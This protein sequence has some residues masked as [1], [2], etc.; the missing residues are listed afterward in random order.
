MGPIGY[1]VVQMTDRQKG[2]VFAIITALSWAVLAI[3]LKYALNFADSETI[4]WLRMTV[5]TLVLGGI[6]A[7]RQPSHLKNLLSPPLLG[8]AAGLMLAANY[9]GFMKGVELT[10]ASNAQIMIQMGPLS[11]ILIG[12]IYF[13]E[14]PSPKQKLG[15]VLAVSGFALFYR[16]QWESSKNAG[17]SLGEGT[18]WITMAAVT[19][20]LFATFQKILVQKHPPQQINLLIYALSAIALFP[21][22]SPS[23]LLDLSPW[24]L[25]LLVALGLNT[26][27]AYG[28]LAEAFQRAPASQV[29]IIISANPLLTLTILATLKV[30]GWEFIS[31]EQVGALGYMGALLVVSG[32]IFTVTKK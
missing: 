32:V 9:L 19:W 17:L 25:A 21:S 23:G 14:V 11:L 12:L 20:A 13:K 1:K 4:V 5:A 18:L 2:L 7:F 22:S 15:F 6:I 29:S 16:D 8:L 10:S 3:G 27:I 31:G 28:C 26:I 24:A 30:F